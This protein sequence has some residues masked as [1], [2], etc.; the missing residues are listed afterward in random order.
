MYAKKI[1]LISFLTLTITFLLTSNIFASSTFG[2]STS[3][4]IASTKSVV[5]TPDVTTNKSNQFELKVTSS[6]NP[7]KTISIAPSYSNAPACYL[8]YKYGDALTLA[9]NLHFPA[10]F[11]K[12]IISN[13]N[14][15]SSDKTTTKSLTKTQIKQYGN[16]LGNG[17]NWG[18]VTLS[19]PFS[20][21][22][23]KISSINGK[24]AT[25]ITS[26]SSGVLSTGALV[27]NDGATVADNL[28]DGRAFLI[29]PNENAIKDFT[30]N[31][32]CGDY[33]GANTAS[34]YITS[35][36][37]V[38][39]ETVDTK[40]IDN[41]THGKINVDL[42][43]DPADGQ[44][45]ATIQFPN[46][47]N[48][49]DSKNYKPDK[50]LDVVY[51]WSVRLPDK[52]SPLTKTDTIF[53]VI[54]NKLYEDKDVETKSSIFKFTEKGSPVGFNLSEFTD[55][56]KSSYNSVSKNGSIFSNNSFIKSLS[57]NFY[58]D[59]TKLSIK[60]YLSNE[61]EI[62]NSLDSRATSQFQIAYV[63][64]KNSSSTNPYESSFDLAKAFGSL[65]S[66]K[67]VVTVSAMVNGEYTLPI[68]MD[69]SQYIT[70]N[71]P[72]GFVSAIDSSFTS[73]CSSI[74]AEIAS[75][76]N[77]A[78]NTDQAN[79]QKIEQKQCKEDKWIKP[80]AKAKI[81]SLPNGKVELNGNGS[82]GAE[83]TTSIFKYKAKIE[84]RCIEFA[85]DGITCNKKQDFYTG[86]ADKIT[87]AEDKT[88]Y[89][90]TSYVW[91][92][93]YRV[94][95]IAANKYEIDLNK[96]DSTNAIRSD[97]DL[98]SGNT[99]A[100]LV[101]TTN[102]PSPYNSAGGGITSK[103]TDGI[104]KSSGVEGDKVLIFDQYK[105]SKPDSCDYILDDK[106]TSV[107][108]NWGKK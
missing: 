91:G 37:L 54:G 79:I 101:V 23:R 65:P 99:F 51:I 96:D 70:F 83:K 92:K 35:K 82:N 104:I 58:E 29:V 78:V 27:A 30:S 34:V 59:K 7:G 32:R 36:V 40:P 63:E 57:D 47:T 102:A 98:Y 22:S 38:G 107:S 41:I 17:I 106:N 72:L 103:N 93:Q 25:T 31:G 60:N 3:K 75:E 74:E 16:T 89:P 56:I 66:G 12:E 84:S 87:I 21:V 24:D 9:N 4:E 76:A 85:V 6:T 90:I 88:N 95:N 8:W 33:P 44:Y 26:Y 68:G 71:Y 5:F 2:E 42:K 67:I 81:K 52:S 48:Q 55:S 86:V 61:P 1:L 18:D 108:E 43:L 100:C 50:A 105:T 15:M 14:N 28:H 13:I 73:Q 94:F 77:Q 80:Y 19:T 49:V 20:S 62:F 97:G 45:K 64:R 10:D 46:D 53:N 11:F 69:P 39:E